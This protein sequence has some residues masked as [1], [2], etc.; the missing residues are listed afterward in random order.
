MAG[1]GLRAGSRRC[2]GSAQPVGPPESDGKRGCRQ[3]RE[4]SRAVRLPQLFHRQRPLLRVRGAGNC[5]PSGT[6]EQPQGA[7]FS[8]KHRCSQ[9]RATPGCLLQSLVQ[10]ATKEELMHPEWKKKSCASSPGVPG[11][12]GAGLRIDC[13]TRCHF[14]LI[15]SGS[16]AVIQWGEC[17]PRQGLTAWIWGLRAAESFF[18]FLLPTGTTGLQ[19]V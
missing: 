5:R 18:G 7:P 1:S 6:A 16:T 17:W 13:S 12:A 8:C 10:K 3:R 15:W 2:C 9:H 4:G 14:G 11:M 19:F